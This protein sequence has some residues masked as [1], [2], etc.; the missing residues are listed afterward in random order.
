MK[1]IELFE[2]LMNSKE[3]KSLKEMGINPTFYWVYHKTKEI[4]NEELDFHEVIWDYDIEPI[5]TACKEYGIERFTISSRM[6]GIIE[7]INEFVKLGCSIEGITE[8]NAPYKNWETNDYERLP[9]III[10]L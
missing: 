8:V 7:T 5:V 4:G 3:N 6:S 2:Q 10:K 1:T 9:A